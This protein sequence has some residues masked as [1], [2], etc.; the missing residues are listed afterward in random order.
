MKTITPL[1]EQ[2]SQNN[3]LVTNETAPLDLVALTDIVDLAVWAG[4]L[5]MENGSES[6]RVEETIRI[7]G[8]G[9]G[10]DWGNVLITPNAI[11][12]THTSGGQI[13]TTIRQAK[14]YIGEVNMSLIEEISHLTHRVEE[15]KYDRFRVRQELNR[16]AALPGQYQRWTTVLAVGTAGAAFSQLF[17]GGWPVFFITFLS[18]A[19]AVVVR[20][21]LTKLAYNY[22][23]VIMTSAFVAGGLVNLINTI[24]DIYK[25]DVALVSSVLFLVPG[26][27]FINS[28]KDMIKG[29]PLVGLSRG[30]TAVLTIFAIALGLLLSMQL[31]GRNLL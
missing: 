12:A 15:G 13:R 16:I 4:E 22:Y 29:Y 9:L 14:R 6:R 30:V 11:V 2:Q 1:I 17:G 7:L 18:A 27:P 3:S 24:H 26:V 21:E 28:I 20:Q 25:P 19:V 5:L 8:I 10:C 31:V 23:L